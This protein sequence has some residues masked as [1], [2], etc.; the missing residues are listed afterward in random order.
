MFE[1]MAS[2]G[3]TCR[4]SSVN[5]ERSIPNLALIQ[6]H[7]PQNREVSDLP[8]QCNVMKHGFGTQKKVYF[9]VT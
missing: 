4:Y 8:V 3:V 9:H 5:G 7:M 6:R 1:E 2:L